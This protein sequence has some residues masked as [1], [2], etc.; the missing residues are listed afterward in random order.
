MSEQI[1]NVGTVA[2]DGTGDPIRTALQKAAANFAELYAY[3]ARTKFTY[4]SA[5]ADLP[6]PVVGVITLT[7]GTYFFTDNVDLVG[8]RLL[9]TGTVCILGTSSEIAS[10][11]STGLSGVA[12]I[13]TTYSLPMRNITITAP[14]GSTAI[15]AVAANPSYVI[16]FHDVNFT[17]CPNI[18]T[19]SGYANAIFE[20]GA[21][22][23]SSGLTFEGNVGTVSFNT[24]IF[25]VGTGTGITFQSTLVVSQILRITHSSM[26]VTGANIGINTSSSASIPVDSYVLDTVN[27]SGGGT[28]TSG[29]AYNNNKSRFIQCK[30]ITNSSTLGYATMIGNAT[31]TT[32]T[33]T[34]TPVKIAGTFTLD[35]L[36]QRYSLTSNKLAYTGSLA[37]V[38]D[39]TVNC[40]LT[41]T[42]NNVVAIYIYKNGVKVASSVSIATATASGKAENCST[43]AIL[44]LTLNDEIDVWAE[45]QTASNNIT[46]VNCVVII[47][48]VSVG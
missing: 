40:S 3:S 30:G 48:P 46:A 5:L 4:V 15:S 47:K 29:V 36:S 24:Y 7:T 25:S 39:I 33:A 42:N 18:G 2:N 17:N 27:F 14:S 6:T 38:F 11:T 35:A 32:I 28:Y 31:A 44:S 34:N 19:I 22:L 13:T 16:D 12:L 10:I 26:V 20:S 45:N 37:Q 8:N 23:N 1:I 43:S 9:C 41:T 21:F